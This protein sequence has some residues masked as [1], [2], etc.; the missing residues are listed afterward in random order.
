MKFLL[1]KLLSL[2]IILTVFVAFT[3][4]AR[5]EA[6]SKENR[7]QFSRSQIALIQKELARRRT[8]AQ[9]AQQT[10]PTRAEYN[11]KI[12]L[13][14]CQGNIVDYKD[15]T[16][17]AKALVEKSQKFQEQATTETNEKKVKQYSA[18]VEKYEKVA[19]LLESIA[20][21]NKKIVEEY[22]AGKYKEIAENE[23]NI[24]KLEDEIKT[25]IKKPWKRTWAS[26]KELDKFLELAD[27]EAKKR[28][29]KMQLA[30]KKRDEYN[31]K[32]RKMAQQR[33]KQFQKRNKSKHNKRG[34]RRDNK[35]LSKSNK[36]P[37]QRSFIRQR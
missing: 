25:I 10:N 23:D 17:Y 15:N 8:L 34:K 27:K 9:W 35:R 29:E 36:Y 16:A 4:T 30:Q 12:H 20:E 1:Q 18:L 24:L 13:A 32:M 33:K 37:Q 5:E 19:Q 6:K 7:L 31:K 28:F 14:T 3:A 11:K 21:Y 26:Q 22:K 2:I